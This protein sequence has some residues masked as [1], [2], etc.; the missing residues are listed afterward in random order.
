MPDIYGKVESERPRRRELVAERTST[1]I[2]ND[3]K[4]EPPQ[5]KHSEERPELPR[6]PAPSST[7][8]TQGDTV[9]T[10]LRL[11]GPMLLGA[12]AASMVAL[13]LAAA[14]QHSSMADFHVMRDAAGK[15]LSGH[16]GDFIYPPP[17][18]FPLIPLAHLPYEVAAA[19]WLSVIVASIPLTLLVLGVRD[20]RCHA[21]TLL[22]GSALA[23]FGSGALSSLLALGT[24]LLWRYRDRRAAAVVLTVCVVIAKLFLWP[25][26][27]WLAATGRRQ[28][29]LYAVGGTIAL[30]LAGW[31]STGFAGF[32]HYPNRVASVAGL[33]Q[34][35]GYSPVA[36][37][38][39]L[40]LPIRAAQGATICLGLLVIVAMFAV[41]RK[42][43]GERRS[44][45]LVVLAALVFT[46]ISW[47]HYF[48]L[49]AV[50]IALARPRFGPLW[51]VPLAFLF[52]P[53]R[54]GGHV[55]NIAIALGAT[56]TITWV[57]SRRRWGS[58]DPAGKIQGIDVAMSIA[59]SNSRGPGFVPPRPTY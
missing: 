29:A 34:G 11:A 1:N 57:A 39:A 24:A 42:P 20:W 18:A 7:T 5:A 52:V 33:E 53:M 44:L 58:P 31:A 9:A 16:A 23:V 3:L 4:H 56:C 8:R 37:G 19:I 30:A 26:L 45:V 38:L 43:D 17:A 10:A 48:V 46:P 14:L 22:A 49:L 28:T 51:L 27:L 59:A 41:A 32:T 6:G 40:G 21:A 13:T 35:A 47:L 36:L 55:G 50:P 12:L 15:L 25:L 2:R 54:S